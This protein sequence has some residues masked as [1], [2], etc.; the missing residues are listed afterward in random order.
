MTAVASHTGVALEHRNLSP[1]RQ[2]LVLGLR[3]L[4]STARQPAQFAPAL[5]FPMMLCAVNTASLSRTFRNQGSP[6]TYLNFALATVV[7][8]GVMFAASSAGIDVAIDIQDGFLDRLVASPVS[9]SAILVGRIGGSAVLG[10][11]QAAFF[12]GVLSIFGARVKAGVP[13]ILLILLVAMLFAV[14]LG[15]MSSALALRTGSSEA[16]QA[17]T[18][19]FFA[20]VFFSSAYYPRE[21]MTGWFKAVVTANPLTWFIESVRHLVTIGWDNSSAFKAIAIPGVLAVLMVAFAGTQLRYRLR[22]PQ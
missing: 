18:P 16:V 17:S 6:F 1:V 14:M 8:Q 19:L 7:I 9:R 3:S 10:A 4:R 22:G 2:A 11:V 15:A 13:G 5:M 12:I 21:K 20:L